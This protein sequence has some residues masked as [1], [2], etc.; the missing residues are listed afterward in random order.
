MVREYEP[1]YTVKE[2]S[3][4]LRT[5]PSAVYELIN[6]NKLPA[7]RLG[8]IKIR[9]SDLEKFIETFPTENMKEDINETA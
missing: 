2:T 8:M 5:N 7:L 1:L 3:K 6:R 4:I 9:G